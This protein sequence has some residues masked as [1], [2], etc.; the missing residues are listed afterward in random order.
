ME[1]PN[2]LAASK[3]ALAAKRDGQQS[4]IDIQGLGNGQRGKSARSSGFGKSTQLGYFDS[5]VILRPDVHLY[6]MHSSG[7]P[8]FCCVS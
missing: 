1:D 8:C 6:S 5:T 3:R 7:P 2:Q 4:K